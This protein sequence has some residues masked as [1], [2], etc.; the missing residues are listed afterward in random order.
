MAPTLSMCLALCGC[1]S[2]SPSAQPV[3]QPTPQPAPAP[4]PQPAPSPVPAPPLG[5]YA[6]VAGRWRGTLESANFPPRNITLI[7][8]QLFD[9]IDGAWQSDDG[10]WTGGISGLATTST[11]AGQISIERNDSRGRC[12]GLGTVAGSVEAAALSLGGTGFEP[13]AGCVGELPQGVTLL[14]HRD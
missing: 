12:A 5:G 8:V 13:R 1:G 7:A 9:C 3:A 2:S 10:E 14:L 4:A 11:Y 6:N